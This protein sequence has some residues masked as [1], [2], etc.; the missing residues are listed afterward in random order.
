MSPSSSHQLPPSLANPRSPQPCKFVHIDN[1]RS[2]A[3][4]SAARLLLLSIV[5][6][7]NVL[8]FGV[9]TLHQAIFPIEDKFDES[10]SARLSYW[11]LHPRLPD[12]EFRHRRQT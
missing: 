4:S 12:A 9:G 8:P 10:Y 1:P 6:P 2:S 3:I 11:K 7:S 5:E